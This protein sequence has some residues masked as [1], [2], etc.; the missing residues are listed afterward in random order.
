MSKGLKD[1]YY[2]KE[3]LPFYDLSG[4]ELVIDEN[5]F[6]AMEKE[7]KALDVIKEQ[8]RLVGNCLHAKNKYAEDGW[9]FV[10]EIENDDELNAWKEV[11]K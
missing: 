1:L 10:K 4:F 6:I 9:V 7:L 5:D 8:F 3:Q 11:L 2:I